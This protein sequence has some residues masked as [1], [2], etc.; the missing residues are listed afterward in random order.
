[1]T[2]SIL[3]RF[4]LAGAIAL[5]G[6]SHAAEDNFKRA[7]ENC[8]A[9]IREVSAKPGKIP[10]G[11]TEAKAKGITDPLLSARARSAILLEAYRDP[12]VETEPALTCLNSVHNYIYRQR[13]PAP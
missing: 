3:Q 13:H 9:D 11:I 12:D 2:T 7:A 10:S 5:T 8:L 4:I 6:V 1:M